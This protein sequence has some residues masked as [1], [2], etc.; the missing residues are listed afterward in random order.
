MG[1]ITSPSAR[2]EISPTSRD[3]GEPISGE[4]L[5]RRFSPRY[6]GVSENGLF[7]I[8][9][10]FDGLMIIIRWNPLDD[11][12]IP[13]SSGHFTGH[14][15][16]SGDSSVFHDLSHPSLSQRWT[17]ARDA[18]Y[19]KNGCIIIIYGAINIVHTCIYIYS[20]FTYQTLSN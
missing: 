4:I 15:N 13:L 18:W 8:H 10:H 3:F 5:V 16:K 1:K 7:P 20:L 6:L 12:G 14:E 2:L 11:R 17:L 19:C 9:G